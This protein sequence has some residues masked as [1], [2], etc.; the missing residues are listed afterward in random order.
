[1]NR[2]RLALSVVAVLVLA[3]VGAVALCRLLPDRCAQAHERLALRFPPTHCAGLELPLVVAH[4]GGAVGGQTYSN[5]LEALELSYNRGCRF[6]ELDIQWTS[7][8]RLVL[9][10]D[11]N[12]AARRIFGTGFGDNWRSHETFLRTPRLDGLT[13][14][15]LEGLV[16]WL[17]AHPDAVV[18]TDV[19]WE[20]L[21][22]LAVLRSE[23]P[24]AENRLIPQI[25]T[26]HEYAGVRELG[27]ER[28]ILTL[29][30]NPAGDHEVAD[31]ARSVPLFA[32]TMPLARAFGGL[33]S[34]L[35]EAGVPCLVHTVNSPRN[36]ERLAEL[37]VDGIYTDSLV[38]C[39][40]E[41]AILSP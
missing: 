36:A 22:A 33:P 39:G 12:A 29:Y 25:Y 30:R 5:S 23:V 40:A 7:D 20:N 24:G 34:V 27:F 17:E 3:T 16:S 37:G 1:V 6:F 28:I 38:G 32:V 11:W 2:R 31:F 18:V 10:H 8:G 4:A 19:K 15:D 9:L 13:S 26:F 35:D 41:I 21:Q 14:L